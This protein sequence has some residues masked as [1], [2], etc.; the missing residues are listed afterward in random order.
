MKE[1]SAELNNLRAMSDNLKQTELKLQALQSDHLVNIMLPSQGVGESIYSLGN[2]QTLE[3]E[4]SSA[5]QKIK[6]VTAS[7]DQAKAKLSHAEK[8]LEA[9]ELVCT[10]LYG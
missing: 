5:Q 10:L 2:T 3:N 4:A 7:R 8:Q 9:E 1:S 6:E